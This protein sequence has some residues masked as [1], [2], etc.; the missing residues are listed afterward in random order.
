MSRRRRPDCCLSVNWAHDGA[1][2]SLLSWATSI[3]LI[4]RATPLHP[5]GAPE[6]DAS[7]QPERRDRAL[8]N[9]VARPGQAA[10]PDEAVRACSRSRRT[11]KPVP[12]SSDAAARRATVSDPDVALLSSPK[13]RS[14][15]ERNRSRE[16]RQ[17]AASRATCLQRNGSRSPADVGQPRPADCRNR[18]VTEA[19]SRVATTSAF[20][21]SSGPPASRVG[22]WASSRARVSAVARDAAARMP[23]QQQRPIVF[24]RALEGASSTVQGAR[25]LMVV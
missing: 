1:L 6:V 21:G 18:S 4:A 22:F 3:G 7:R 25:S 9:S 2:R 17:R 19:G 11:S 20:S 23:E 14:D 24:V 13:R 5:P 15:V 16:K 10:V 8:S 12:R